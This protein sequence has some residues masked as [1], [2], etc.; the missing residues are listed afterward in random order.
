MTTF[1]ILLAAAFLGGVT[2]ALAGGGTFLVFPALLLGGI[3]PVEANATASLVL[4][5]GAL[6]S[7]WVYKETVV[8]SKRS[9]LVM[10]SVASLVGSLIGSI[11]LLSTS[12]ATFASLVPW[13]LLIATAVFTIAP[14]LRKVASSKHGHQS[15]VGLLIGQ[16]IISAYG[17]YFGAG[18]GVLMIALY[19]V[20]TNLE[21]H[22]ASGL[23]MLCSVAINILAVI[24]FAWRG[25][26]AYGVG[27]P[28]L[29]AGIAGGYVGAL[30]V[31]RMNANHARIAIL[32]YAWGLTAW[33]FLKPLFFPAK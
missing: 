28:M 7:A 19:L 30:W 26:L 3:A 21:V 15:M 18:M 5:P 33:F 17:G 16:T 24:I 11:L 6:A 20:V 29:I 25:A 22:A 31:K 2:N 23:R 14:W 1:L 9:F 12:N 13:L 10:M 27:V 4:L 8:N 32:I